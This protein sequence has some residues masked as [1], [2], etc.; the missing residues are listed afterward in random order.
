MFLDFI[1]LVVSVF[2]QASL[3]H[4]PIHVGLSDAAELTKHL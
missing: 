2:A 4:D 3:D 1:I